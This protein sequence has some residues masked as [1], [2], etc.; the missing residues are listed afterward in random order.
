M[1]T[2]S[3]LFGLIA[4]LLS[5]QAIA[6]VVY[7]SGSK[8]TIDKQ[9][10]TKSGSTYTTVL[11]VAGDYGQQLI[12]DIDARI[13]G[14][15]YIDPGFECHKLFRQPGGMVLIGTGFPPD[16]DFTSVNPSDEF[17]FIVEMSA[18]CSGTPIGTD[19]ADRN[20]LLTAA[21]V[22]A[23]KDSVN[24]YGFIVG[25]P[26]NTYRSLNLLVDKTLTT[27]GNCQELTIKV[28]GLDNTQIGS[29]DMD[30]LI[31]ESF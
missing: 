1:K 9:S 10:F 2:K 6:D 24:S 28:K 26:Y 17:R 22:Q 4:I 7:I 14:N 21:Q 13:T 20:A 12:F 8:H 29:I 30:I 31:G 16:C 27:D 19:M 18:Y 3:L 15:G 25:N 11:S 23:V 5:S